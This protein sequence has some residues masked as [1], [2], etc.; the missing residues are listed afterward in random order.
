[1]DRIH[2]KLFLWVTLLILLVPNQMYTYFSSVSVQTVEYSSYLVELHTL[3]FKQYMP[4]ILNPTVEATITLYFQLV[5][6]VFKNN[7]FYAPTS[8]IY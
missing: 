7:R 2:E 4:T 1:M 8:F 3:K 5:W 6:G